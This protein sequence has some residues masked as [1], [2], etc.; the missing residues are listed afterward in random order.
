MKRRRA[1][2]GF[3]V[4]LI[5]SHIIQVFFAGWAKESIWIFVVDV[6]ILLLIFLR[7]YVLDALVWLL[8]KRH[9]S[10][11]DKVL[12]FLGQHPGVDKT[13][14]EISDAAGVSQKRITTSLRRLSDRL[15]VDT[16]EQGRWRRIRRNV[17]R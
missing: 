12:A 10:L 17:V 9:T 14:D 5:M 3:V 4:L 16:D 7:E 15:R 1:V 8:N 13:V 6:L 11:D 2:L